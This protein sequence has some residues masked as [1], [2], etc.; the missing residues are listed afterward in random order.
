MAYCKETEQGP[1]GSGVVFGRRLT[2]W[3]TA[4]DRQRNGS[5]AWL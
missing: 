1:S 2:T 3:N 4:K 5:T